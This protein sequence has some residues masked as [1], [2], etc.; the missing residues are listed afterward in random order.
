MMKSI[1]AGAAVF[2]AATQAFA[3]VPDFSYPDF[4]MIRNY[5]KS[6]IAKD[7]K[8]IGYARKLGARSIRVTN[9]APG[10]LN[11][12]VVTN[13]GCKFSVDVVYNDWPGIDA[14]VVYKD[15]VCRR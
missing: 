8:V 3:Y 1:F 13:N 12:A 5:E 9:G 11:Y 14:I 10:N 6:V 15:A 7:A 2:L 4:E